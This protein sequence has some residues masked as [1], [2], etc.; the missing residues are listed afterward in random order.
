MEITTTKKDAAMLLITLEKMKETVD[1]NFRKKDGMVKGFKLIQIYKSIEKTVAK[2]I[3]QCNKEN[4]VKIIFE[5]K[6][7]EMVT[8][9]V[10]HMKSLVKDE[11]DKEVY[12]SFKNIG[13]LISLTKNK[14]AVSG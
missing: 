13:Y 3:A 9:F 4:F 6:Q 11:E 14:D 1:V 5:E 12:D 7:K 8:E 10:Q 2:S